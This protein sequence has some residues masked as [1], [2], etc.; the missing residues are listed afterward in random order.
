MENRFSFEQYRGIDLVFFGLILIVAESLIVNA[1][2]FWFPE[3][4][5]VVSSVAVVTAIVMMRWGPWAAIHAVLGGIVFCFASH[6]NLQQYLVYC[7]GNLFGLGSLLWFKIFGKERIRE[8]G[9]AS[10]SFGLGTLLFMQAG[11]AL[12]ALV[13]GS[14]L[15]R[16]L[17]F[18]TTDALS[19]LFCGVVIW[20]ARRLDG[21]FE[22]QKKYLLRIHAEEE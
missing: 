4:L 13:L 3:Q 15:T 16:C 8:S 6:A 19:L 9:F 17:G 5:Y 20:I 10:V 12:I 18:F 21:V 7:I 2:T 14:P 22:D 1:A 11:R